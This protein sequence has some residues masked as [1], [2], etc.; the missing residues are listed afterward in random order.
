MHLCSAD[1][2]AAPDCAEVYVGLSAVAPR[3]EEVDMQEVAGKGALARCWTVPSFWGFR[4]CA[5]SCCKGSRRVC[6]SVFC[7]CLRRAP[8]PGS[9]STGR[10]DPHTRI[11]RQN[12]KGEME[13]RSAKQTKSRL[14]G[15]RLKG[16][17]L[18]VLVRTVVAERLSACCSRM[19]EP[20]ARRT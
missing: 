2:C 9:S 11:R 12:L 6:R 18:S 16:P 14:M 7:C 10:R 8:R 15:R 4:R 20:A 19:R 17:F 1:P 5:F 3:S 13:I